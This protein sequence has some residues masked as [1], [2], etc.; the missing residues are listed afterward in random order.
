MYDD[1]SKAYSQ[2]KNKELEKSKII[3]EEYSGDVGQMPNVGAMGAADYMQDFHD[4]PKLAAYNTPSLIGKK[5]KKKKN[6]KIPLITRPKTPPIDMMEVIMDNFTTYLFEKVKDSK[7]Q[8]IV[9]NKEPYQKIAKK[10]TKEERS[11]AVALLE[12]VKQIFE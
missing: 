8:D 12:A 5:D 2:M 3:K 4:N 6:E 7:D 10:M 1:Y 11:K 9:V